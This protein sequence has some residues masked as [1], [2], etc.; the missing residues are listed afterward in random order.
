MQCS[1][2]VL[3][4]VNQLPICYSAKLSVIKLQ[5][6]W[7]AVDAS[8]TIASIQQPEEKNHSTTAPLKSRPYGAI[9][10]ITIIIIIIIIYAHQQACGR[11][12]WRKVLTAAT[13]TYSVDIVFW[14]ATAFPCW[15]AMDR[16]WKGN[17]VSLAS[18]VMAV[19]CRPIIWTSSHTCA[20][21]FH[22]PAIIIIIIII[23][24]I[25]TANSFCLHVYLFTKQ[26]SLSS[27]FQRKNDVQITVIAFLVYH[28]RSGWNLGIGGWI[29]T[30]LTK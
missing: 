3:F 6:L 18:S 21:S 25:T 20:S 23:I 9:A 2:V 16:R 14:K 10:I 26:R 1:A 24:I 12:Y 13:A 4:H 22:E 7:T 19:V 29:S 11:K 8:S 28:C 30:Q 15:R 5:R 27:G 17:T